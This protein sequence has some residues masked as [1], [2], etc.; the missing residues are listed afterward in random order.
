MNKAVNNF[1]NKEE[2]YDAELFVNQHILNIQLSND[3][4]TPK[5]KSNNLTNSMSFKYTMDYPKIVLHPFDTKKLSILY[6]DVDEDEKIA[7]TID[8]FAV[9]MF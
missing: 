8:R 2:S 9:N 1:E 7:T 5:E 6:N 4:R 3:I